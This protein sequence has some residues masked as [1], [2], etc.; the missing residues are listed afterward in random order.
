[1]QGKAVTEDL[2]EE[3]LTEQEDLSAGLA[4]AWDRVSSY[5]YIQQQPRDVE[6]DVFFEE[7]ILST[8]RATL[9]LQNLSKKAENV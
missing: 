3:E 4:R 2:T 9:N 8:N 7:L 5:N 1:L 6:D